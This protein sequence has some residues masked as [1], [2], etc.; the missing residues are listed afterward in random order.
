VVTDDV[1][2]PGLLEGGGAGRVVA[3]GRIIV[4]FDVSVTRVGV[5]AVVESGEV[6]GCDARR[7]DMSKGDRWSV[8]DVVDFLASQPWILRVV[9]AVYFERPA[10]P[11]QSGPNSAFMAGRAFQ[12]VHAAAVQL[13]PGV[14][15]VELR[16]A[17]WKDR[18]DCRRHKGGTLRDI[19]AASDP[20]WPAP[21]SVKPHV[22]LRALELGFSP[23]GKQ[24]AA[25]AGCVAVAG[26]VTEQRTGR[27]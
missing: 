3:G 20:P 26:L 12:V 14:L 9:L 8:D 2:V 11:R 4:G 13:W 10:M 21:S 24:D 22:Y 6:L 16:D 27:I 15:P 17:E 1:Q 7:L 23:G 19:H 18:S 5:G 25:D